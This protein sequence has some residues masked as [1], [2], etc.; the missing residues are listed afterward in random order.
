M[1]RLLGMPL[2][3]QEKQF[4]RLGLSL[5]RQTMA[6]WMIKCVELWLNHLYDRMHYHLVRRDILHADE[7]TLQVLKEPDRKAESTSYMWVYRTGRDGPPI[8]LF[9]YQPTRAGRHARNFLQGFNGYLQADAYGG[10]H[11][12]PNVVLVGCWA[13]ARRGFTDALKVLL[14][15]MESVGVIAKE[16]LH[17]C[18][19]L[20]DIERSLENSTAEERY[21]E[22]LKQSEPVLNAFSAW[23]KHQAP[24]VMPKSALGQA[25]Q[26]CRNQWEPLTAFLKDGRTEIHNNRCE[27]S[28]KLFVIGRKNWLFANTP[29]GADSSSVI[30][31]I[32]ETAKENKL[33]P[34]IY[35]TYVFEKLPNVD[36]TDPLII[37]S[38]LP[39]SPSIPEQ[40]RISD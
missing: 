33:N 27:R 36:V 17:Y 14:P 22:R 13:H 19:Q 16:G 38:L 2:Y 28:I 34:Y 37:D 23:L 5:S 9:E 32:V 26:Y 18:N 7:T 21:S 11:A 30:Y 10:Y 8:I 15:G 3:R 39:W 29:D 20:F 40:C 12:V 31:S 24:R 4:E 25:I 6:R 1:Q 35:L